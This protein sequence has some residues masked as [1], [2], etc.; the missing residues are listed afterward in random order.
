MAMYGY[1]LNEYLGYKQKYIKDW[2]S[3]IIPEFVRTTGEI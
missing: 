3:D 1:V 2:I